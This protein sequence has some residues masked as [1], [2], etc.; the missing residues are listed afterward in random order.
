MKQLVALILC[1]VAATASADPVGRV[2]DTHVLPGFARLADETALLANATEVACNE[3]D[4]DLRAALN[5]ALR[6]WAGVSH[7]RFGPTEAENRAFALAFWPDSRGM[8][9]KALAGLIAAEDPVVQDAQAFAQVSVA[10][11]GLYALEFLLY[12]ED[13]TGSD[14]YRCDLIRA[15][16]RDSG[17]LA[18][19][20]AADWH[21]RYAAL[22]R[23]PGPDGP[24]RSQDEAMQEL[25]KALGTG[26]QI[27]ADLRLGRPLGTFDKPR[28]KRAEA[29]RAGLSL[30]LVIAALNSQ[31]QL[32]LMLAEGDAG[33]Q[34]R[35]GVTFDR[36]L[37]SAAALDD[38]ALAGV[39]TPDG[40][41]RVEALQQ[42]VNEIR[43]LVAQELGPELGDSAGFNALD[44][45]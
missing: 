14:A 20:M 39:A 45:D 41:V 16:A 32:A 28:P 25:F 42:R 3:R 2:L 22:M 35:L 18:Q 15:I 9:P 7:L 21:D 43:E 29:W 34:E 37:A 26:L 38:P 31:K 23:A 8:T 30:S 44:G 33:L 11:R 24:Y 5:G 17:G 19:A 6:A 13:P 12:D 36:V 40:R 1:L 27:T 4:P 10:A